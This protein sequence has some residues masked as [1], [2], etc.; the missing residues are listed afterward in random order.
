LYL[1]DSN[2]GVG[3]HCTHECDYLVSS[4]QC[5][6][7]FKR[8]ADVLIYFFLHSLWEIIFCR[9]FEGQV[10][11]SRVEYSGVKKIGCHSFAWC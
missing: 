2:L 1:L 6:F 9:G 3:M 10:Q 7:G 11:Q 5:F 8:C 4:K